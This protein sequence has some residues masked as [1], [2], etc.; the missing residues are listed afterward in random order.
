VIWEEGEVKDVP[1]EELELKINAEKVVE[2]RIPVN[3]A[4]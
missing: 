4:T 1:P 2:V 3:L